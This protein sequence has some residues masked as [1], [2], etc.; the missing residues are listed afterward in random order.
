MGGTNAKAM[1]IYLLNTA[2]NMIEL[3]DNNSGNTIGN[4]L[5]YFAKDAKNKPIFILDNIEINNN[6]IPSAEVSKDLLCKIKEYA[7]NVAKEVTGENNIPIYL[8]VNYNDIDVELPEITKEIEFL[9]D[10][11]AYEIYLDV[12]G[13]WIDRDETLD[14]VSLCNLNC[15]K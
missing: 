1:P 3:V 7:S 13:G 15:L 2:F 4:A 8:G 5:C 6:H 14:K 10:F 9:G 12:F 11:D